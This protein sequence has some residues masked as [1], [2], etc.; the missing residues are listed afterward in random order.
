MAVYKDS[1]NILYIGKRKDPSLETF[2]GVKVVMSA[3][4]WMNEELTKVWL[5]DVPGNLS[6]RY[7][8]LV[9]DRF[10]CHISEATKSIIKNLKGRSG[11]NSW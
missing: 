8:L 11:N 7:R 2:K 5:N 1:S 3:N 10:M 6:F 9:W 4:G